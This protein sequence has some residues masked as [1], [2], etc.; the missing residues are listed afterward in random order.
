[1]EIHNID[2]LTDEE[3]IAIARKEFAKDREREE[4]DL[5]EA[6]QVYEAMTPAEKK[7]IEDYTDG[8]NK[9][10]EI[11]VDPERREIDILEHLVCR[12]AGLERM[13]EKMASQDHTRNLLLDPDH[14]YHKIAAMDRDE[15]YKTFPQL[16]PEGL[17]ALREAGLPSPLEQAFIDAKNDPLFRDFF[18]LYED[19]TD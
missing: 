9:R 12:L 16:S 5:V 14:P 19:E 10:W 15:L 18:R 11:A 4:K 2:E 1:M 3:L 13:A 17:D 7:E 8:F 6:R